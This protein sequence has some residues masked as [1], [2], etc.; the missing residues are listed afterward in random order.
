MTK[1]FSR[2]VF[3]KL[4][5]G[6]GTLW[7]DLKIE[8]VKPASKKYPPFLSKVK[9]RYGKKWTCLPPVGWIEDF[10]IKCDS[11]IIVSAC[12]VIAFFVCW[13][14]FHAQRLLYVVFYDHQ[15][16]F[17]DD[18]FMRDFFSGPLL[19]VTGCLY[20]FSSTVNP[21][22]YNL[23]SRKYRWGTSR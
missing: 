6:E 19:Y 10:P 15:W 4:T 12:V 8:I 3:L 2:T 14:P 22:L 1:E 11:D 20:Y 17:V 23:L 18:E 9:Q 21:I 5:W 7:K 16:K 13:A